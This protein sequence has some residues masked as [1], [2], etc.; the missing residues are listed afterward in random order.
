MKYYNKK[1]ITTIAL[2]ITC[3][4]T[5]SAMEAIRN[6]PYREAELTDSTLMEF[7]D[8]VIFP[9]VDKRGY[10]FKKSSII[11]DYSSHNNVDYV[12]VDIWFR[13][14]IDELAPSQYLCEYNG[15]YILINSKTLQRQFKLKNRIK[16][17]ER[18]LT[19][20]LYI[21]N[22]NYEFWLFGK[23]SA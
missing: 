2:L 11:I 3:V 6:I 1:R 15:H 14:Y 8:D 10:D 19:D 5:C 20:L 18:Y 22:D 16:N 17:V 13:D 23:K 21:I 9:I 12:D 4:L 7:L